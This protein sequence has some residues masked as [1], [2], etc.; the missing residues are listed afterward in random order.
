MV[1]KLFKH[2]FLAYMRVMPIVYLVLFSVALAGRVIQFFETDSVYYSIVNAFSLLTYFGSVMAALFF[3]TGFA[4]VRF[5]K[6]MF[7]GEG[8]LTFTLPVTTTQHILV[9]A[10][11]AIC[12]DAIS[13]F[14]ILI[15]GCIL[16]F[17]ELL[18]EIIK[19]GAFIIEKIFNEVKFQG[20]IILFEI[21]L[22]MVASSFMGILLY[23]MFIAIGQL[24]RK[25]RILVSIGAYFVYDV[26]T[27]IISTV[28]VIFFSFL[29]A[30]TDIM[31]KFGEFAEAH[32]YITVHSI[33]CSLIVITLILTVV[34]F[35]VVR[36]IITKKLN[37]E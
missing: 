19:A 37:L 28:T 36:F 25:H 18:V 20:V 17:G 7:T 16:T 14:A 34:Y 5:Y 2:E 13:M 31:E 32:P 23:Y 24:A 29:S 35:L 15:S 33:L 12:F 1:K 22:L 27:Q 8:Y 3:T 26:I 11:T 6:N 30:S 4:I 9:K 10:I 21:F